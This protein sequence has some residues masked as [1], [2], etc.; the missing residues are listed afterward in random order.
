MKR[1][2]TAAALG[3]FLVSALPACSS[4][5]APK[6]AVVAPA[7]PEDAVVFVALGGN[8]TMNRGLDDSFKNAWTQ[9]LYVDGLPRSAM[10]VNLSSPDATAANT[11][12]R[13]LP[14]ALELK[15]TLVTIWL[16]QGDVNARTSPNAFTRD[17]TTIVQR[18]QQA[19]VRQIVL[20][21]REAPAAPGS[22]LAS[23]VHDVATATGAAYVAAPG[24]SDKAV[25]PDSQ[26]PIADAIKQ[27]IAR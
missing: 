16:G 3:L 5:T 10:H 22:D 1:G 11:I 26:K 18:L 23:A 8:E 4:E 25:D 17:L 20:L 7:P 19:G 14:K 13:Q 27:R 2:I 15:P 24:T 9:Q 6:N 21:A 12:E